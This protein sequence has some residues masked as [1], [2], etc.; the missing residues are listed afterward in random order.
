MGGLATLDLLIGDYSTSIITF[1]EKGRYTER[2]HERAKLIKAE[3][4]KRTSCSQIKVIGE[5]AEYILNFKAPDCPYECSCSCP[6]FLKYCICKHLVA[7]CLLNNLNLI[8]SRYMKKK[9]YFVQKIKKGA[10][11]KARKALVRD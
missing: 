9:L 7:Y 10:P 3:S 8:D 2:I 11:R 6:H 1:E 5:G 4:F